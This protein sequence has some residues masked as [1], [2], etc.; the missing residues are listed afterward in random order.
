MLL[1]FGIILFLAGLLIQL[2]SVS[3]VS[4]DEFKIA[5]AF[6]GVGGVS[7]INYIYCSTALYYYHAE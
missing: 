1:R 4:S 2:W 5:V 7:I 3:G 6:T